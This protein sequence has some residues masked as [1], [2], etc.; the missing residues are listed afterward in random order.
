MA[1]LSILSLYNYDDTI[2][3]DLEL[4]T[5]EE[6]LD[7]AEYISPIEELDKT[8]LIEYICMELAEL[9]LVYT[10]PTTL[11][12]MIRVWSAVHHN[13]WLRLWETL[14]YKYNPI[15]NKDGTLT[16]GKTLTGSKTTGNTRTTT[17][18]VTDAGTG[19]NTRTF[20][21]Q[22]PTGQTVTHEVTGYDSNTYSPDTKDTASGTN[23]MTGTIGDSGTSGNTR[24]YNTSVGDSGSETSGGSEDIERTEQG[25]IGVTTTQQMIREQREIIR[26]N[27][28][29]YITKEFKKQ[30]C[31]MVY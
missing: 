26:F 9:S 11:K 5:S 27:M 23:N 31:I 2:F 24:T 1:W 28:Y 10:E 7:V 20:N 4:P 22:N 15:W 17:G 19:A 18:T 8:T 30:F 16:E 21:T 29:E 3:D 6:L 13:Q 25:N 14:L 12:N